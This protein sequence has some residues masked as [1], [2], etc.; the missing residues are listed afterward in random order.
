MVAHVAPTS[1]QSSSPR[2]S[3]EDSVGQRKRDAAG[4]AVVRDLV[5][6]AAAHEA[7]HLRAMGGARRKAGGTRPV[8]AVFVGGRGLCRVLAGD[9]PDSP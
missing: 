9:S 1:G 6:G 5:V 8:P 4:V 3:F 7:R 2:T